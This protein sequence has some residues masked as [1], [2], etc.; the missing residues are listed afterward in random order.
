MS[1]SSKGLEQPTYKYLLDMI[2]AGRLAPGEH[3]PELKI[4]QEF[5]ISRTPVR[6]AMRRLANEGLIEIYPNR[7]AKVAEYDFDSIRDIGVMRIAL[8]SMSIK[9]AALFGSQADF[10]KLRQIALDCVE[11]AEA[12]DYAKRL[13]LDSDF[14]MELASISKN[15]LL[16]KFHKELYLRVQFIFLHHP[17]SGD[18]ESRSLRHHV[19]IADALMRHDEKEALALITEHLTSFYR[20]HEQFPDGFF[21]KESL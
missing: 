18:N 15:D 1:K 9:L 10:L 4:S 8:D 16:L 17:N 5:G 21:T 6:D 11:A 14:H 20:L 12:G 19:E 13:R 3:I 2:M 7:F